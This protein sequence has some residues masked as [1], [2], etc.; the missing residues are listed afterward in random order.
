MTYVGTWEW[1]ELTQGSLRRHDRLRL[2][3]QGISARLARIPSQWRS[4]LLGEKADLTFPTPPDSAIARAAEERAIELSSPGLYA[5]CLRTWAFASMF[6]QRDLVKHDAEL[7]YL[8]CVLHD[9]GLTSKHIGRD[10]QAKC[11]AIEGGRAAAALIHD[12]GG[13]DERAKAVAEAIMLHLNVS[14]PE[15]LGPEAHLLSKGV[16][17]DVV[18]R[19]LH[20][21]PAPATKR[22]MRAGHAATSGPSSPRSRPHRRTCGP[23]H[24][25]ASYTSSG[26]SS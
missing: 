1:A 24:G 25:P 6:A 14:V 4:Q 15:R 10:L 19:R 17:L 8:A 13:S 3:G 11:F 2:I 23:N 18:G 9:L 20:Q 22:V 16:S 26:S 5:H 12:N 7:L 21:I